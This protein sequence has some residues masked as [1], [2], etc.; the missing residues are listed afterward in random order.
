MSVK[1]ER[2]SKIHWA[3]DT[4]CWEAEFSVK[5]KIHAHCSLSVTVFKEKY[6]LIQSSGEVKVEKILVILWLF[7]FLLL[8]VLRKMLKQSVCFQHFEVSQFP[9]DTCK[10]ELSTVQKQAHGFLNFSATKIFSLQKNKLDW[11]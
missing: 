9:S 7:F 3:S 11:Q 4:W 1:P 2:V 6:F 8:K 10:F 5:I